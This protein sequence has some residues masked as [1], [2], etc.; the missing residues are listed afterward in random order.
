MRFRCPCCLWVLIQVEA[1]VTQNPLRILLHW[2]CHCN[3][4]VNN[5]VSTY[6]WMTH[7]CMSD[8]LF[9]SVGTDFD[10]NIEE[11]AASVCGPHMDR[12]ASISILSPKKITQFWKVKVKEKNP[13]L[14]LIDIVVITFI[15]SLLWFYL[16]TYSFCK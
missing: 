3:N 12:S 8:H 9:F 15:G 14:L 5:D 11:L 6:S 10:N 16:C 2:T 7:S 1:F 4:I 13:I